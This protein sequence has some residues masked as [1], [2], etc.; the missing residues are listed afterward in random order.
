[1]GWDMSKGF[2]GIDHNFLT[3]KLKSKD[4]DQAKAR[5]E[6]KKALQ[7]YQEARA[8]GREAVAAYTPAAWA[9]GMSRA[10]TKGL[11]A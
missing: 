1:M 2:E 11:L 6:V 5:A 7:E 9:E 4:G 3:G 8:A 10:L